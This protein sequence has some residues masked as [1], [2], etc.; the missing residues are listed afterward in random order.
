MKPDPETNLSEGEARPASPLA[1]AMAAAASLRKG[2]RGSHVFE[3]IKT[4]IRDGQLR[5][6]QRLRE[7]DLAE[8]LGVSRTP[9]R[10]ALKTLVAHGLVSAT[11]DG[12]V[13]RTLTPQE[14]TEL[15][16]AWAELEGVAA[17]QAALNARPSD[18]RLM[19][20]ICDRWNPDFTAER[21]GSINHD[22]HQAIYSAS[23]NTFLHRALDAIDNSVA[24]L[25]L[26]TYTDAERRAT[27]GAEHL[28]IVEAIER[29]DAQ[30]AA[31]AA[32]GHIEQSEKVRFLLVGH[33]P[34][35]S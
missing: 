33:R 22:L 34:S 16:T 3:A 17:R 26:Q 23:Y 4:A 7:N 9:V 27:A 6:G 13:V 10:E 11:H 25:G 12:L 2:A 5:P 32:A 29:R 19:R 8:Q 18:V 24:L 28:R 31:D 30:G 1:Q 15:Y 20:S 21:L 14:I 35:L